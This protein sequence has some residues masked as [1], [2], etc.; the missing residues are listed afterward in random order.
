MVDRTRLNQDTCCKCL[1][2]YAWCDITCV[3]NAGILSRGGRV[4]VSFIEGKK[5]FLLCCFCW[6]LCFFGW[7]VVRY[8]M[9]TAPSACG[10]VRLEPLI[11]VMSQD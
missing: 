10:V 2:R 1:Y 11:A 9:P 6:L 7:P 3:Q 4:Y 8:E 5:T